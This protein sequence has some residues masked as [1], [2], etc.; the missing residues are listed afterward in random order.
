MKTIER[1]AMSVFSSLGSLWNDITGADELQQ[2]AQ[3]YQERLSNTAYQRAVADMRAAG[4]NPVLSGLN[5]SGA[6]TPSGVG[7]APGASSLLS[8]VSSVAGMVG[9]LRQ[10]FANANNAQAQADAADAK[11][12]MIKDWNK[13]MSPAERAATYESTLIPGGNFI[14]SLMRLSAHMSAS[15]G[16]YD[17]ANPPKSS[18]S[19]PNNNSAKSV[20]RDPSANSWRNA[21][22]VGF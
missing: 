11:A 16:H 17:G 5:A 13:A 14:D 21:D 9:S 7:G 10:Q 15:T 12:Q 6:S 2:N 1:K 3:D 19:S 8:A 20:K 4:L 18:P 22:R